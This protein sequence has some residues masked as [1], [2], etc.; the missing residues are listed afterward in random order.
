MQEPNEPLSER[1]SEIL[2]L[3]ATGAPNKEIARQLVISP[4]TVKV[5]LRNIFTKIGVSSRTEAT[6]YALSTGL[7]TSAG[8]KI[9]SP[10]DG[11]GYEV[12]LPGITVE[13]ETGAQAASNPRISLPHA[14]KAWQIGLAVLLA[15]A[16]IGAGVAAARLL[17]PAPV[18][19]P[20]PTSAPTSSANL[21]VQRWD[22][23]PALP[24]PRKAMGIAGYEDAFYLIAGETASG[25]DGAVLRYDPQKNTWKTLASKPTAVT[26]I[27]AAL[28]GEKI[29]V[30]GGR[31]K[32]G[33]DTS[34]LEVYNP[35]QD[36]W[37]RKASLPM[38]VSG[39]ALAALDGKLY[40]F[41]GMNGSSYLST[42][43]IYDPQNDGWKPGSAMS[44]LRAF[45]TAVVVGS[46]IHLLGG[47]DGSHAL[48]LNQAYYPSRDESGDTPWEDFSP[49]P[50]GRYKMG[51]APLAGIIFLFGG[52]G[53]QEL[54][55]ASA[56][57]QY[58]IQ[59]NQ[60]NPIDAPTSSIGAQ[61][62]LMP[63]GNFI[64]I[65]G[66]QTPAGI[67]ATSLAYQAIFTISVP[68]LQNAGNP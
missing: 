51:A 14:W 29:Y 9:P 47:F 62:A 4:N 32:D 26:N 30:P 59:A 57:L 61:A 38:P 42:V 66:G 20:G 18:S 65:F 22:Q 63:S 25:I 12:G 68:V 35:R 49:L 52:I 13:G 3:V 28:L 15:L 33:S 10:E 34:Q 1:E 60:W 46:R 6:L 11:A 7:T 23:K 2:R 48:N 55:A 54:P 16:L 27:Q 58:T 37:E 53:D 67:S 24:A 8:Q 45:S 43:Y 5:H 64:Y 39:Y 19:R 56:A 44:T 41:G 36:S 50:Q 31:L 40:L 17:A 21:T